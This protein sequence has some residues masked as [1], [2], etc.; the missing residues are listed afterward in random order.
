MNDELKIRKFKVWSSRFS[1]SYLKL[2]AFVLLC[3]CASC[4]LS[5]ADS[6]PQD[7]VDANP[8]D[9]CVLAMTY[10]E[11][12]GAK[13][14]SVKNFSKTIVGA[15][16]KFSATDGGY[17]KFAANNYIS[18][19]DVEDLEI[20]TG[21]QSMSLWIKGSAGG[22]NQI[23]MSKSDKNDPWRGWYIMISSVD[24]KMYARLSGDSADQELL[25]GPVLTDGVWHYIVMVVDGDNN[26]LEVYVDGGSITNK[27]TSAVGNIDSD[28]TAF[29]VSGRDG[30]D[31][32]YTGVEDEIIV[33]KRALTANEVKELYE[34]GK[35]NHQ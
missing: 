19:G 10:N 2:C 30:S 3:L 18:L 15:T 11:G 27:D 21:S 8:L 12:A 17:Y 9:G 33:V 22:A 5:F 4:C 25:G 31:R 14:W 29:Q 26:T 28:G 32:C 24:N 7:S 20:G 1:V 16:W 6:P 23:V 35:A 34:K 13:D